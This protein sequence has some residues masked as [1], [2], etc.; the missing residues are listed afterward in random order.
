MSLASLRQLLLEKL[1]ER[2]ARRFQ[3]VHVQNLLDKEYT[4]ESALQDATR[5]GL[6]TQPALPAALV[7]KLL[8]AFG[9]SGNKFVLGTACI[10]DAGIFWHVCAYA[11][12]NCCL[13]SLLY[14]SIETRS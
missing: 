6:Q 7:D 3:D 8:K 10:V 5:D 14:S 9:Q 2:D 1:G 12:F 13:S 4:D 11:V